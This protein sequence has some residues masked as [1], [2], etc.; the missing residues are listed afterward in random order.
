MILV[1]IFIL[2]N[3]LEGA[4][5]N[6]K[7]MNIFHGNV[8]ALI[9]ILQLGIFLLACS[10]TKSKL[11]TSSGQDPMQEQKSLIEDHISDPENKEKLL[12]VVDEM[13]KAMEEFHIAYDQ[14]FEGIHKLQMDYNAT[15]DQFEKVFAAFNPEY[16]KMLS[17][18]VAKRMELK[19]L[20]TEEE[21][22]LIS[23]RTKSYIPR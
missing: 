4:R 14:Y 22:Q 2:L 6:R 17:L 15:E 5:M 1:V 16:E 3:L 7:S 9:I 10:G 20:T 21:W 8:I 23:A 11:N 19:K 12:N 13:G 18:A